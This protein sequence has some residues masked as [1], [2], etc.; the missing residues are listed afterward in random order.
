MTL[1]EGPVRTPEH[2]ERQFTRMY[3]EHRLPITNYLGKMFQ[4]RQL[5]EELTQDVFVKAWEALPRYRPQ[6]EAG[7]L[8]RIAYR[9][10]IDYYR[11]RTVRWTPDWA[12]VLAASPVPAALVAPDDPERDTLAAERRRQVAATLARLPAQYAELLVLDAYY[13]LSNRDLG[14]RLGVSRAIVKCRLFRARAAFAEHW[15]R[16]SKERLPAGTPSRTRSDR[17]AGGGTRTMTP[18]GGVYRRPRPDGPRGEPVYGSRPWVVRPYDV[19]RRRQVW[20]GA[21]ATEA[22]A[23]AVLDAWRAQSDREGAQEVPG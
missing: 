22:E 18:T 16:V 8:Y 19:R 1:L 15:P 14:A 23:R 10:G 2:L 7:W 13:G 20:L 12:Q 17:R 9:V 3:A 5:A 6:N 21:Y 4:Q 11:W